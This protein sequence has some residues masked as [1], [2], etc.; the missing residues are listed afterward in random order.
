MAKFVL[1]DQ[2]VLVDD[3]DI[4]GDTNAVALEY[5]AELK[6]CSVLQNDTRVN[7]GG[8]KT[9]Q[10]SVSGFYDADTQDAELFANVGVSDKPVSI[11]ND[12]DAEGDIAYFFNAV[13]GEYSIGS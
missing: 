2:L 10:C 12:G 11:I 9:V 7:I 5:G 3:Y 4:T 8:L 6:D 13:G 1:Y